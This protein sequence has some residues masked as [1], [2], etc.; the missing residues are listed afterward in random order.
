MKRIDR[1]A[2]MTAAIAGGMLIGSLFWAPAHAQRPLP[3]PALSAAGSTPGG[4]CSGDLGGSFPGCTVLH[5]GNVTDASLANSGLVNSSVTVNG[6]TCALGATCSPVQP[7]ITR[8]SGNNTIGASTTGYLTGSGVNANLAIGQVIA[9]RAGTL[10]QFYLATNSTQNAGGTLVCT[11]VTGDT[12]TA[13]NIVV[14]VTAGAGGQQWSDLAHTQAVA[15]GAHVAVSC[16]NNYSGGAS[17]TIGAYSLGL[18]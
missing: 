6:S 4:A 16:V 13:S 10:S 8:S 2:L 15:A 1:K 17:A 12:P 3:G 7:F 18:Q 14:T 5:L 9:P 11:V